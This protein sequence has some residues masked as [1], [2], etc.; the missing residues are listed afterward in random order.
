[1]T[2]RTKGSDVSR[3]QALA[4]YAVLGTPADPAFDDLAG[5][6]RTLTG[7]AASGVGFV[8][9]D[10]IWFKSSTGLGVSECGR[11]DLPDRPGPGAEAY[12]GPITVGGARFSSWAG[13]PL[14]TSEG[15]PLG[16][17]FVLDP[18]LDADGGLAAPRREGLGALARQVLGALELRRT[19]LSYHAVVDG[20]GHVVFKSDEADQL[21]SLTP[22]WSRVTGFGVVRSLGRPLTEFIHVADRGQVEEQFARLCDCPTTVT[23][24]CRLLRLMGGDVPVEVIARPMV[25]ED[26]R[27]H[28]L[29]GVIADISER[30]ARE[31]EARHAQKLEALGRLSA[32]LAHEI[33]TPIQFVGDNTRFLAEAY[34]SLSNLVHVS[35]EI[36]GRQ[37]TNLPSRCTACHGALS[38]AEGEADLDFL[39]DEIPAAI[40]QSLDGLG[41]VRSLVT[42]M[43]TFSHPGDDKQGPADLNEALTSS[44]TVTGKQVAAV[45]EIVCDLGPLPPVTCSI[46][47]LNQVFLN[48]LLNA[49]DAIVETGHRGTLTISSRLDGEDALVSFADTGTGMPDEVLLRI[50]EPFFTT[51]EVG[52]GTGQGLAMARA[53]VHDKH[54]GR[55]TVTSTVGKGSTFTVVLPVRGRPARPSAG[56]FAPSHD[57]QPGDE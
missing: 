24:E 41:R 16:Q 48:L 15:H 23:F 31:V 29:V 14:T 45:A 35:H 57:P 34:R 17:L 19:L 33:N 37:A 55:I 12:V 22:T 30:R 39:I 53:V 20:A 2:G 21:V 56:S 28:G 10:R 40:E 42:A 44:V 5:L 26:G 49:V 9:G 8:D 32:G 4:R 52:H 1:M 54:G 13:A 43:R 36:Q 25:A 47:D 11:W 3:R 7:S 51:K 38:K 27:R 6:A 18:V 50:F 46:G